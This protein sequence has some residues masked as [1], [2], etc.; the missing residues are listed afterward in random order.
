MGNNGIGNRML[1]AV[2]QF[3]LAILNIR[4]KFKYVL[5]AFVLIIGG[6]VAYTYYSML[7]NVGGK[8]DY[9]EAM[10][11]IEIKD[12]IDDNFIDEIDRVALGN[13]A[14]AAMVSGLNDPWS[15]YMSS[16]E[17]KTYQ[18]S[19][20]NEYDDIGITM[21]K[22]DSNGGFQV[23]AVNP[24]SPAAIAG[25]TT[26]MYITSVDD[27]DITGY[28]LEQARTAIRSKMN[29]KFTLGFG[30][31]QSPIEVDC[32]ASYV[33][34][35]S[36]RLEKTEAG[37]VQINNFEAGSSQDAINA[38]EDLLN[39]GASALC[40]DLRNNPGGLKAEVTAFLDYLL[41]N[42]VLFAEMDKEGKQDVVQS[43]GMC[44][45]LPMCVLVN[46]STFAEA[47]LCAAVIQEYNWATILGEA[48]T[49]KT[50]TQETISISDG[51][52]LRLSTGTYITGNGNDISRNGGVVPD[53]ITYNSDASATGT[54]QGT[55]GE[56][57]GTASVSAD[58]QLMAALT[59]LSKS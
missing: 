7:N 35:V 49:G 58:E 38:I 11:Y 20:S 39:Q 43:D 37:Y 18:L 15:K 19:S 17:Y 5:A 51:S 21:I 28:T 32:S 4:I 12:L 10:R 13:Y 2:A 22:Y 27:E 44:I 30:R 6:A 8:E 52:A 46:V 47:E 24:A 3:F 56:S 48:T 55:T 54:T 9:A 45:Q 25:I 23:I 1:N 36:Y 14:A 59:L 41:P 57:T 33:S 34:P 53:V 16:D 50:R 42:G 40:I 26:G 31:G 29:G